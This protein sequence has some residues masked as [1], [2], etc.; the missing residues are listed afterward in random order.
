[1]AKDSLSGKLAVILHADIAGSTA[2]VQQDEQLAHERIQDAFRRFG[3]TIEK[4]QGHI[5]ELR[6]DALLAQFERASDAVTAALSFQA[7]H[8]YHISRLKDDLRPTIRVGIAMGEVVIADNTVTGAGVVLAQRVEQLADPGGL[9]ITAA[10][11]E[12]LPR[13]MPFDLE[14]LGDQ[15]LKGFDDPVHV[16]RVELS[17][18]ASIPPPQHKS[19]RKTSQKSWKRIVA[20]AVVV[21]MAGGAAYWFKTQEPKVESASIERMAFPLPDKPSIAVLPFTNM[22]DDPQ[23]E[24]F[25]DGITEDLITDISQI[26]GLF[27]I[28]RNSVFT[29]KGKVVKVRQVAEELGVRYVLEGSVRRVGNQVRINAQL[30]DATTGGH[31]WAKRYDGSLD[32][33]FSMQDQVTAKI[34]NALSIKLTSQ[35]REDLGSIE[36]SSTAAHDAYL[37]GLSYYLRNTPADNAKAETHFK[38]AVELDPEFNRAYTALAN[39][40]LKAVNDDYAKALGKYWIINV[41]LAQKNLAKIGNANFADAHVVRARMALSKHQVK[42]ALREAELALDLSVNDVAASKAKAEALIY[43]GQYNEGRK[44]ANLV[45]RLDPAVPADPLYLIGLSH[46]A[47]GNYQDAVDYI[48]RAM[49]HNPETSYFAG[50]LAVAYVKLGMEK[51]SRQAFN[52]YLDG[53]IIKSP[54][55]ADVVYYFPFQDEEVL[56]HLADGFAAVG[57]REPLL[58]RYMKLTRKTRLSGQEIKSLLFGRTIRIRDY[59]SGRSRTQARTVGGKFSQSRGSITREGNSWIDGDLL[60]DRW[61]DDSDEITTCSLIFHSSVKCWTNNKGLRRCGNIVPTEFTQS[62]EN[63]YYMVTDLGPNSFWVKN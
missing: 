21:V 16:Y 55:I 26:S 14:D 3:E 32:D 35:E 18:G 58:T 48:E 6:G 29:Y 63:G 28:A 45:L 44:I 62:V 24:Y 52:R 31:I 37:Q 61:S 9:C 4:Y 19:Q 46:L 49:E 38:R 59:L 40:Y 25:A 36:T 50:P 57:A 34:V 39:V 30:I 47:E 20:I 2:L 12:S 23:Q 11:H 43:S 22:S 54:L 60:C 27:V 15:V 53:W 7:D 17:P 42:V 41:Y 5:L 13:R 10:L 56:E 51:E 1:M 33:V 8:T